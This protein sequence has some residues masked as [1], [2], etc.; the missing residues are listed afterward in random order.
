MPDFIRTLR[1]KVRPE[2]YRW[3]NAAAVEVNQVWN[4]CNESSYTAA[5]RTD[6]KQKWF[7]GFDLCHLTAGASQY[8]ERIGA[9]TIQRICIE[10]A[11]KRTA[12]KKV[13]LRW[14]VSRGA[15]RSLGWVPFKAANLKRKGN[16]LRC[17]GKTF[18]VFERERLDGIQWQQGCFAQDAVGDW[19]L[20]LP[21]KVSPTCHAAA[22]E[23]VGIDLGIKDAAVTSDGDRLEAIRFY[24]DAQ[25]K[26][27]LLQRRG[28]RRQ[29]KRLHRRVRRRRYDVCHKF[30]TQIVNT[31]QHI[32]IGNVSSLK[33]VKTRMAKSVLDS[34]WGILKQMLQYKGEAAGRSVKV[35]DERGTTQACSNCRAHTG[36]KG[37]KQLAVRMW[38]C[39]RCGVLHDR[40]VNS[41][42][43]MLPSGFR[44]GTSVCGNEPSAGERPPSQIPHLRE[45]ESDAQQDAA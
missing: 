16:A 36:P 14:R 8:F 10:Y 39:V 17:C 37:L 32:F 12:A 7:S 42:R 29:T 5:T 18:R 23:A 19:W 38:V 35:V 45:A 28:H 4:F 41:S 1:L 34:G 9:D 27:A 40:D 11:S 13:K 33:L 26:L 6:R 15:R 21:V 20:C 25:S 31:Y 43:N 2:S 3:L 44:C 22:R 24:R 30:S